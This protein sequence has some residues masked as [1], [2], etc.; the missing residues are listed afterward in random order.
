M[1]AFCLECWNKINGTEEKES[2]YIFSKDLFLCEGC[3]K[4][5]EV[6]ITERK[7]YYLYK[8]KY[9]IFPFKIFYGIIYFLWRLLIL[10]YLIY[11]Y[12]KN[13]NKTDTR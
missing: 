8:F 5:K 4:W 6:I 7:Y 2:K 11:Q 9:I 3:G 1:A 13:K 10:P 12:H